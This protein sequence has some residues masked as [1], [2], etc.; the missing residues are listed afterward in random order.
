MCRKAR[1]SFFS[2]LTIGEKRRADAFGPER[3]GRDFRPCGKKATLSP[4]RAGAER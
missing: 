2:F 4:E 1:L 3:G